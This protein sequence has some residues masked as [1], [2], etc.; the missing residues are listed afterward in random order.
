MLGLHLAERADGQPPVIVALGAHCDDIEIGAGA[1]LLRLAAA[2]PGLHVVATV[3]T[4]TPERADEAQSALAAFLPGATLDLLV[5]ALRDGRLPDRWDDAKE[6]VEATRRRADEVGGADLV[7]APSTYDAHQD[8]RLVAELAPTA[9]R[10]QLILGYEIL[11]WD[12]DLG[13]PNV[14]VA[15]DEAL[16]RHKSD[17]L[18]E[19][20]PSQRGHGWFDRETFLALLRIRGVECNERYAEAFSSTKIA[21][22]IDS[23]PLSPLR[24][25]G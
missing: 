13:R 12:G 1:T 2:H 17:L 8:H 9:F 4:S 10:D 20:F 25:V 19:H 15:V 22:S 14:Y 6:I 5:C 7:L 24:R 16:A 23:F 11:K 3:L 18:H 21:L